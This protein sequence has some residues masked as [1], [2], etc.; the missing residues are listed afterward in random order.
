MKAFSEI[1]LLIVD[2]EEPLRKA[3]EFDFKRKGF[4]VL[5]AANGREAFDIVLQHKVDVVLTDVRMPGGDGIEL[6]DR[7]R[8]NN[9]TLPV[10]MF[11]TGFADISPEDAYH[12]GVDAIIAKPFDRK[13]LLNAVISSVMPRSERWA[14]LPERLAVDF[15]IDLEFPALSFV[16]QAKVLS[17]GRGGMFVAL[18]GPLPSI[19][20]GVNFKI[21]FNQGAPSTLSGIGIVR[22]VRAGECQ[23]EPP[24]GCGIEFVYLEN[25]S[26]EDL[27]DYIEKLRSKS[28]IPKE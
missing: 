13:A 8:E 20:T 5:G 14:N 10:V 23:P 16:M 3:I 15:N 12:R 1:T 9:T 2:D 22:W 28:F 25:E 19:E 26:R 21:R 18:Q 17:L 4:N 24:P 11:V 27:I 7:I 6:L